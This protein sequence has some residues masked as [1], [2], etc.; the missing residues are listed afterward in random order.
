M[1]LLVSLPTSLPLVVPS[2]TIRETRHRSLPLYNRLQQLIQDEARQ[3]WVWWNEERRET[4]T[5]QEED[6][7]TGIEGINDRNDRGESMILAHADEQLFER[8]CISTMNTFDHLFPIHLNSSFCRMIE[9]TERSPK[10][11]GSSPSVPG[12]MSMDLCLKSVKSW[13]ISSLAVSTSSLLR[14][15]G[16]SVYIKR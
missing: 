1:D 8:L 14:K 10:Q 3:V 12:N 2:T 5:H 13:S 6:E 9:G 7:V 15:E 16:P 4:A 11:K